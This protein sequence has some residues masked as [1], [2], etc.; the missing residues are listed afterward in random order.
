MPL[1]L[2]AASVPMHVL[3][4]GSARDDDDDDDDDDD[5]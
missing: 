4:A 2:S 1:L 3:G 5:E